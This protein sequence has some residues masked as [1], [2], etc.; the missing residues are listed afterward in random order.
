MDNIYLNLVLSRRLILKPKYLNKNFSDSLLTLLKK[1]V[2]GN[3]IN[4]GYVIE[5]SVKILKRSIGMMLGSN[6]TGDI[7]YDI[8]YSAKVCNPVHGNIIK[9]KIKY[10]NKLGILAEYGPLMIVVARQYHSDKNVFNNLKSDD[11]VNVEIIGTKFKLN[12]KKISVV[13]KIVTNIKK[14]KLRNI[15]VKNI[16]INNNDLSLP[17]FQISDTFDIESIAEKNEIDNVAVENS[18]KQEDNITPEDTEEGSFK[19]LLED[20]DEL[21]MSEEV[22]TDEDDVSEDDESEDDVLEDDESED[23]VSEEDVSED[24][25]SE[26]D[27]SE[28][29]D[30]SSD[31]DNELYNESSNEKMDDEDDIYFPK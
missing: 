19:N 26:D 21:S 16:V 22:L 27:V 9:C 20:E 13:G 7:T 23:D 17:G 15:N 30:T 6:F 11:E 5:E 24:D 29:N 1:E 18:L 25:V 4:E 10:I 2:E 8:L 14:K 12:D 3:C 28:Y 31:S